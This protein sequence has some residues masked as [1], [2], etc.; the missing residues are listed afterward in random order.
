MSQNVGPR[1]Q[2]SV[3]SHLQVSDVEGLLVDVDGIGARSQAAHGGQVATV[4]P[5]GL[6]DEDAAL[7][8]AGRLLDAVTRLDHAQGS[9]FTCVHHYQACSHK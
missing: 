5:H 8:A 6:N 4:A 7:G 1:T 2:D 3:S 9:G